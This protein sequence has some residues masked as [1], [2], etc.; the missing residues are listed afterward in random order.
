M[1]KGFTIAVSGKGGVGKTNIAALLIRFL[2]RA[3]TVLAMDA[4]PDFNLPSALGVTVSRTVGGIREEILNMPASAQGSARKPEILKSAIYEIL[5]ETPRF[6]II[7]MGRPEGEGCYCAVNNVLS[8]TIDLIADSYDFTV[9]D[10]EAGLEHLSRR[11][12]R[13]VDILLVVTE[14][15]VN[16][17]LTA[18]RIQELAREL[19]VNFGEIAIVANKITPE[20]KPR[21]DKTARENDIPIAAYVPYDP[22][23]QHYDVIGKPMVELPEDSPSSVAVNRIGEKILE[24]VRLAKQT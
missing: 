5:E 22:T 15:T 12:A 2:S 8:Q 7:V 4:D 21:I 1:A 24:N 3:G 17:L 18:K 14:P 13:D 16:G 6:D 9:I 19:H 20:T 23:M 11:T 10:C